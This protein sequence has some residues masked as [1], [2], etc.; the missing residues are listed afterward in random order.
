MTDIIPLVSVVVPCYNHQDFVKECLL[1]VINQ[2][3]KNIQLIV[4]DDGSKDESIEIIKKLQEKEGFIFEAQRNIGLTKTLNKALKK[5]VQGKYVAFLASDDYWATDKI[6]KQVEYFEANSNYGLLFSNAEIVNKESRII[7]RFDEDRLKNNCSLE[8]LMLD[9]HGIPALTALIKKDVLDEVGSYDE[10]LQ[11]EDW[12]MWMRISE[13]YQLGY[14]PEVLA[15]YRTH[16]ENTSEKTP[17]MM[18]NRFSI[19]QKW[20]EKKPQ[21]YKEADKY[22]KLQAFSTLAVHHKAEA[23]KYLYLNTFNLSNKQFRKSIKKL[24]FYGWIK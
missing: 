22:W 7:G 9:R 14:M 8:D 4:I 11:M 16:S 23:L 21:L 15:Y 17:L 5:Y 6:K 20:K 18:K 12:D 3:Y 13:R 2:S 10:S 19:L 1:S 24:L